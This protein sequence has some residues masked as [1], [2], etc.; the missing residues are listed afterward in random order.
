MI[1]ND[2]KGQFHS[3]LSLSFSFTLYYL[4]VVLALLDYSR[5]PTSCSMDICPGEEDRAVGWTSFRKGGFF[6]VANWWWERVPLL[7]YKSYPISLSLMSY[8]LPILSSITIS[9]LYSISYPI[10][11]YPSS[12]PHLLF[13]SILSYSILSLISYPILFYSILSL[14]SYPHLL[15]YPS[16]SYPILSSSPILFYSILSYPI[17]SSSPILP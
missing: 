17:L 3:S 6:L 9:L 10:L 14:I 5:F 16:L 7:S 4:R 2:E 11:S 15:S 8:S 1:M 12:K 13:Y